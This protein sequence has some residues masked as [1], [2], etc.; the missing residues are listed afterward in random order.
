MLPGTVRPTRPGLF[1]VLLSRGRPAGAGGHRGLAG[2]TL[3]RVD[4]GVVSPVRI[5]RRAGRGWPSLCVDGT[6]R[7]SHGR[8]AI[9]GEA[10]AAASVRVGNAGWFR[11]Q[12]VD[13]A[14]R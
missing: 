4:F 13:E 14:R 2:R 6:A 9:P 5:D 7:S 12:L 11:N 3:A 8:G 10:H 1:F